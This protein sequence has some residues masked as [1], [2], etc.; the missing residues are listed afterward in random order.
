MLTLE[1]VPGQRSLAELARV[2]RPSQ[3]DDWQL[4]ETYEGE[5]VRQRRGEQAFVEWKTT[6]AEERT[7]LERWRLALELGAELKL[8]REARAARAKEP[9]PT[10]ARGV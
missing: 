10:T 7:G 1:R 9:P 8:E 6:K 5:M 2:P 4:Y 3:L